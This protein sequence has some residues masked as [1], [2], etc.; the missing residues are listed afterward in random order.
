MPPFPLS[1]VKI[2]LGDTFNDILGKACRGLDIKD[3]KL[4]QQTGLSAETVVAV[5]DG[6]FDE[7]AVRK[8]ASVLGLGADAL[9]TLGRKEWV[10]RDPG[11]IEGLACFNT[12]YEDMTVNIYVVRDPETKEGAVFDTGAD[13]PPRIRRE[14]PARLLR[15]LERPVHFAAKDKSA[16]KTAAATREDTPPGSL[17]HRP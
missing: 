1:P 12:P 17:H 6:Q 8:M 10:P 16:R 15:R 7:E 4:A 2:P 14:A 9:V 13:L 3:E 5:K 11:P